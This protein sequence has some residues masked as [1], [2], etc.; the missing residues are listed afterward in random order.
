[1][2]KEAIVIQIIRRS[3][4]ISNSVPLLWWTQTLCLV[5][6]KP[7]FIQA[8][9]LLPAQCTQFILLV[10][11]VKLVCNHLYCPAVLG[12]SSAQRKYCLQ[13]CVYVFSINDKNGRVILNWSLQWFLSYYGHTH[14]QAWLKW[15][16]I[17]FLTNMEML[18]FS[19]CSSGCIL[20]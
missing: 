1:M 11:L 10:K 6:L 8:V 4:S 16:R 2:P 15:R 7:N 13:L 18:L 9:Y 14:G 5:D 17:K 12:Q 19:W 3:T 20:M